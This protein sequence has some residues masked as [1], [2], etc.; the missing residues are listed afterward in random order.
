MR[1]AAEPPPE[2]QFK[3]KATTPAA[4]RCLLSLV[5]AYW[6]VVCSGDLDI[7]QQGRRVHRRP[8][9]RGDLHPLGGRRR[10]LFTS[11]YVNVK[12]PSAAHLAFIA[13]MLASFRGLAVRGSWLWGAAAV[14]SGAAC[15]VVVVPPRPECRTLVRMGRRGLDVVPRIDVKVGRSVKR[16]LG[17]G[18][19]ER[20]GPRTCMLELGVLVAARDVLGQRSHWMV[21]W[22]GCC[23]RV[24][25]VA[26]ATCQNRGS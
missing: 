18:A 12:A 17:C 13:T 25:L 26:K 22:R 1:D 24:S 2:H 14:Q 5:T 11:G 23:G 19:R 7:I 16:A 8:R 10:F 3:S 4:C 15:A 20:R 21:A 6:H 9:S